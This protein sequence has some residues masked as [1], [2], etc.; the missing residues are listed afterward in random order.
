M[1][2]NLFCHFLIFLVIVLPSYKL[3]TLFDHSL[4][5][6]TLVCVLYTSD[7]HNP[8]LSLPLSLSLSLTLSLSLFLFASLSLSLSLS[9]FNRWPMGCVL[10]CQTHVPCWGPL[11][12]RK[13]KPTC[14]SLSGL[15]CLTIR[16]NDWSPTIVVASFFIATFAARFSKLYKL[17]TFCTAVYNFS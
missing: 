1:C 5:A 2:Q 17:K 11:G 15:R 10:Q 12:I 9:L 14:H 4:S 6:S 3:F 7:K 8:P 16:T 13:L